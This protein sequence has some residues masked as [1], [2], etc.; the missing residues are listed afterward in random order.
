MLPGR[1]EASQRTQ[2]QQ[3]GHGGFNG[4]HAGGCGMLVHV[5][6]HACASVSGIKGNLKVTLVSYRRILA[7]M[8][9]HFLKSDMDILRKV[10]LLKRIYHFLHPG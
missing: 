9:F 6:V 8:K 4:V 1:K 7:L 10:L 5:C 3:C 2:E